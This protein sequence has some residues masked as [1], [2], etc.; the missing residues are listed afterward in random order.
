MKSA[1]GAD[2]GAAGA[3]VLIDGW[4]YAKGALAEPRGQH[5]ERGRANGVTLRYPGPRHHRAAQVVDALRQAAGALKSTPTNTLIS[6]LAA[7]GAAVERELD[8]VAVAEIAQNA[9]M[10]PAMIREVLPPMMATWSKRALERLLWSEFSDPRVLR[11]FIDEGARAVH[12]STGVTVHFGSGSVPGA[13]VGSIV[14]AMLVRSPML[15]KPGAG[16]VALTGRFVRA[17]HGMAPALAPALAVQYWPGGQDRWAAWENALL[18]SADQVVVYGSDPTI[19]SLRRRAPAGTR[20]IEHR[21]RVGVAVIAPGQPGAGTGAE[22]A[23][24]AIALFDQRGCVSTHLVL[25][26]GDKATARSWCARLAECLGAAQAE[27]PA[28]PR[29]AAELSAGHQVRGALA[30]QEASGEAIDQ[31][32]SEGAPWRVVLSAARHFRPVGSRTAWVVP[33]DHFSHAITVL[34]PLSRLLQ[35]VGLAGAGPL[36]RSV[37]LSLA[38]IGATRIVSL[39]DI[40]FPASDWIHDG[41]RP[42]RELIQWAELR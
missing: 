7:A 39:D 1:V 10:S 19:E 3:E 18:T 33:V 41:R 24:R 27:W 30:I 6:S 29:S 26:T 16:D 34:R 28:G 13:T 20:L 35:T 15:V 36:R 25:L 40:A 22:A 5:L 42:L 11:R 14:R 23:A 8:E 4:V 9:A 17:L 32:T 37:A 21:N 2:S 12:A 38:G 31:W